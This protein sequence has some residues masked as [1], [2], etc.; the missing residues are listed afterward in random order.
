MLIA[1]ISSELSPRITSW[2]TPVWI[3]GLGVMAGLIA[4]A[5]LWGL[6]FL[7][8]LFIGGGFRK[9]VHEIP[10]IL[11]EGVLW[12][13]TIMATVMASIGVLGYFTSVDQAIDRC[14]ST[15]DRICLL[16]MG[17]NVGGGSS[18]DG[19]E[20]L[21]AIHRRRSSSSG[22]GIPHLLITSR[23]DSSNR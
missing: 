15:T 10:S 4:L 1:Q 13:T 23:V 16:D 12:P 6:A 2:L 11:T 18:A 19:T 7:L 17:D 14:E 8:S 5:L 9:F 20:L 22:S 3:L 21:A